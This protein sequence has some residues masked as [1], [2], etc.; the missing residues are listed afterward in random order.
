MSREFKNM[1]EEL[2]MDV[3]ME[4]VTN[5]IFYHKLIMKKSQVLKVLKE[6]V[7][8]SNYLDKLDRSESFKYSV[9]FATT[10]CKQ[11]LSQRNNIAVGLT[12]SEVAIIVSNLQSSPIV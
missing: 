10:F 5:I 12:L 11:R 9:M 2:E 1:D 7:V 8:Q 4:A 3:A 6:T